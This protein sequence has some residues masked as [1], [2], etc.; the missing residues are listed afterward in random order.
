[1]TI[2]PY[3][4]FIGRALRG[5]SR[6]NG[7]ARRKFSSNEED[8]PAAHALGLIN[9]GRSV[10]ALIERNSA[11]MPHAYPARAILPGRPTALDRSGATKGE[12]LVLGQVGPQGLPRPDTSRSLD[13]PGQRSV[14]W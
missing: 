9:V 10:T 13:G 14:N 5:R 7:S 3:T 4:A 2:V 6:G 1:M 11:S 8:D 12:W